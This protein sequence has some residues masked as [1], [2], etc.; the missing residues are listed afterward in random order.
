[1]GEL[2]E[3]GYLRITDRKKDLIVTAHGK[4]IAPQ[5]LETELNQHTL[6]GHTVVVGDARRYITALIA[7]DAEAVGHWAAERG[8]EFS[9]ESIAADPDLRREIEDAITALNA[10]HARVENIRNW[11]LLPNELSVAGGEL[12]PT[13]KVRRKV[14]Y[15][16]YAAMIEEMYAE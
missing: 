1:M 15:T 5:V 14:V 3:F 10:N 12:T 11:R 4:N 9:L 6:I 7:L 2:D 13:L 8:K 16:K